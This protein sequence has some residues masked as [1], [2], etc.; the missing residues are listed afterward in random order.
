MLAGD[1]PPGS[2]SGLYIYVMEFKK[3]FEFLKMISFYRKGTSTG[4][5]VFYRPFPEES[6]GVRHFPWLILIGKR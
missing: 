3:H 6:P 2:E 1:P 5:W 4:F